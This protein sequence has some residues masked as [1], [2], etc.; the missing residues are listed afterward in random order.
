ML[1]ISVILCR[2]SSVKY[3]EAVIAVLCANVAV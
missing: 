3:T 1:N 2:I